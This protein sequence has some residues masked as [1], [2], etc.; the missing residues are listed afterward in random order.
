MNC[1]LICF[2]FLLSLT[3]VVN[4]LTRRVKL[5]KTTPYVFTQPIAM[6]DPMDGTDRL[7]VAERGGVIKKM[8][9]NG[10]TV[11]TTPFLDISNL[12]GDC[13]GYCVER[14]LLGLAFHP[15]FSSNKYFFIN[16]TQQTTKNGDTVLST[17]VS[18]F[19]AS[20]ADPDVANPISELILL[21]FEQPRANHNGGDLK[22]GPDGYLY[23]ASGDGG[24]GGDPDNY[25]QQLQTMLGKIL[26]I[27]VDST[28]SNGN[29][30]S[31][32]SDNPFV[33]MSSALDE[34]WAYG[35]RNPWRMSFDM[36][37]G[38]LW[39]ADVG[40]SNWEEVNFQLKSSK[41][42]E[43]YGWRLMEGKHCYESGCDKNDPSLTLPIH[44][45]PHNNGACSV[46]GGFVRRKRKAFNGYYFYGDY[47]SGVIWGLKYK[48]G[49]W[50][51]IK[52][53]ET[54]DNNKK[55]SITSFGQDKKG[56]VHV[57]AFS[58]EIY[59]L[60]H[61]WNNK[62]F[63][64]QKKFRTCDWIFEKSNRIQKYCSKAKVKNNCKRTCGTC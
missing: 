43:N 5:V 48:S 31:I 62:N 4:G 55:L 20:N 16:Y 34:I 2:V 30:Y 53:Y 39:I 12:L 38:H 46:T 7:F 23:I 44:N 14:G 22:F 41:G 13:D 26:R 64:I 59:K 8:S 56:N 11:N 25:G 10:E 57:I 27:D 50:K 33:D 51:N 1:V 32:P 35:L 3:E 24:G 6:V 29:N 47:C 28:D 21:K 49:G 15:N 36:M 54:A 40:Q 60:Q 58:G 52:M 42:G 63:F 61:C 45:Y 17:I 37:K 18:R 19:K 9:F